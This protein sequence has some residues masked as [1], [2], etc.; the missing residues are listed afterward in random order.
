MLAGWCLPAAAAACCLPVPVPACAPGVSTVWRSSW[1]QAAAERRRRRAQSGGGG[2][3]AANQLAGV[4]GRG[5]GHAAAG[6]HRLAVAAATAAA[7]RR[8][9][10]APPGR[11]SAVGALGCAL[12]P[13]GPARAAG[14]G[15]L[16]GG[17]PRDVDGSGGSCQGSRQRDGALRHTAGP[18]QGGRDLVDTAPPARRDIPRAAH[19]GMRCPRFRWTSGTFYF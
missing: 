11:G 10:G 4:G 6:C 15:G 16:R 8:S 19:P 3:P 5:C 9:P 18:D 7:A 17:L 1:Q 2:A 12:E 13:P 14:A